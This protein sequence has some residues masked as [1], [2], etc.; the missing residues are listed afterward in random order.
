[1][2]DSRLL[3]ELDISPAE[4]AEMTESEYRNTLLR[5]D[6]PL[7]EP[8]IVSV[9]DSIA[10]ER[11]KLESF[12]APYSGAEKWLWIGEEI[13]PRWAEVL[14]EL[15]E[16]VNYADS[17]GLETEYKGVLSPR[18]KKATGLMKRLEANPV[19]YDISEFVDRLRGMEN[20]YERKLK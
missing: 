2:P 9:E 20:T 11:E 6:Y 19:D 12:C 16:R 14:S 15:D 7:T 3:K 17:S 10:R 8:V 5:H 18:L 13:L 4:L 1:M